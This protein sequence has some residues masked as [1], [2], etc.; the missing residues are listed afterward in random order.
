[1]VRSRRRNTIET[2][3]VN[4]SPSDLVPWATEKRERKGARMM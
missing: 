3:T 1:M 4:E 2:P